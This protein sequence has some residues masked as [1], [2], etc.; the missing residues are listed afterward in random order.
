[1]PGTGPDDAGELARGVRLGWRRWRGTP[2]AGLLRSRS[3]RVGATLAVT[4]LAVVYIVSRVDLRRC[5]EILA[6][7]HPGWLALSAV[8]TLITVPPQAWRWQLMLRVRGVLESLGW[9]NR[10]YFVSYAVGQVLPTAVG[11]DASRIYETTRRHPGFGSPIAGSVLLER[12]IGGAVTLL[13]AGVG[14]LLAWGEYDI[15]AY[16]WIELLFV[17]LT[18][19]AGVVFFSRR[20]RRVL[21]FAVPFLRR[22]RV[23]RIVRLVYEGVHGYRDHRGTLVAVSILTLLLQLSRIVAIW[24]SG[25]AVG[26]DLSIRPY[27]VLGPL[28]FLVM[29]I[30]FTINGLAVREAFFVSF[31][32]RLGID[33]DSAFA[34]GF[35]FFV[36]TLVLALPGLLIVC[37]EGFRRP[38]AVPDG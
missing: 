25:K 31:L 27:I 2:G 20:A 11:G 18:M 5:F 36:M 14:I 3:F 4:A 33:A 10:A 38:R 26:I 24:A 22:L 6:D 16:L 23:E 29:L 1:V 21:R 35:L 32:G 12:A 37:W 34:C 30:P 7:A 28:L 15:G 9:L 17:V 13:L 19:I 8:L